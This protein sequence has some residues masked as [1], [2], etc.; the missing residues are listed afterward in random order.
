MIGGAG[1]NMKGGR[2]IKYSDDTPMANLLVSMLQKSGVGSRWLR[3]I[4]S[5]SREMGVVLADLCG[6][7][8]MGSSAERSMWT[9]CA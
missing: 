6:K 9:V 8:T 7:A 3:A 5:Y 1:G 2:Y 4:I